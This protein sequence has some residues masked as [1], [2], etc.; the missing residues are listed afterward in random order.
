LME[1]IGEGA[2]IRV[3]SIEDRPAAAILTLRYKHAMTYKYG[4][5]DTSFHKLGAMQL[6]F[7]KAIQ[8][9]KSGGLTEFDM[10]RSDWDNP[11]LLAFKDRWGSTRSTLTYYRD[12][13]PE[14]KRA[15]EGITRRIAA[16]MIRSAPDRLLAAAGSLLYRHVG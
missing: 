1:S 16:R 14:T 4:C 13:A 5:S 2:K 15:G 9:A 3:A 8:E 11:G 7:W 6:L 10:G 12:P